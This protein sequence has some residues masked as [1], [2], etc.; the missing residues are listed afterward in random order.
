M[1][2]RS[3]LVLSSSVKALRILVLV[4]LAFTV[5]AAAPKPGE[6]TH[7]K[8]IVG[9]TDDTA[10]WMRRQD[11]IVGV[12]R[13]L[14]LMAVRV[15]IPWRPGQIRPTKLQQ[16]Y[17]HRIA[18]MVEL[19][20]RIVLAVYNVARYAPV[21]ARTRNQYC[22]FLQGAVR[23]IPLIHDVEIWNRANSHVLAAA[24]RSDG[25]RR[26]PCTLLRRP[27]RAAGT[28]QRDQLDRVAT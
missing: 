9:V 28:D 22:T 12:H 21:T 17:L 27:A 26:A 19:N 8:I 4:S 10:K 16:T 13:D 3:G 11:G 14:R 18:R 24:R 15:T 20:D 7:L 25:V 23:R 2:L 6:S 5:V 1:D